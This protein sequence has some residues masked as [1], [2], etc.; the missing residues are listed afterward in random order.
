M[1]IEF[2]LVCYTTLDSL[3]ELRSTRRDGRTNEGSDAEPKGQS[4][5]RDLPR[6]ADSPEYMEYF[7]ESETHAPSATCR[8]TSPPTSHRS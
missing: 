4:L 2:R 6:E 7:S 8:R 3:W 1:S 5:T